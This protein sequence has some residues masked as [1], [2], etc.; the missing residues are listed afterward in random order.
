VAFDDLITAADRATQDHLGGVPGLYAP[1]VGP[2]VTVAGIF[3]E[4]YTVSDAQFN[5]VETLA[6]A[7][8]LRLEDLPS[9]PR[10]EDPFLTILGL[11][12]TVRL[13]ETDGTVGGTIRLVLRR[14]FGSASP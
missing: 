12:Y 3:D 2:A 14:D 9:D 8:V 1:S 6:P 7:V 10:E 4:N 13:R 11:R 5:G